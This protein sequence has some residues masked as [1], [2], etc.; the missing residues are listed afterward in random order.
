VADNNA[1]PSRG[2][3]MRAFGET[4]DARVRGRR[5]SRGIEAGPLTCPAP[6]GAAYARMHKSRE[7]GSDQRWHPTPRHAAASLLDENQTQGV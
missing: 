6:T 2:V 7:G 1:G 5:T 4:Q 3:E